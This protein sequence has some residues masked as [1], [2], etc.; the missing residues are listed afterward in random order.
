MSSYVSVRADRHRIEAVT[1]EGV[2]T[3]QAPYGHP[4]PAGRAVLEHRF[5]GVFGA[6][7]DEP[8]R[9]RVMSPQLLIEGDRTER[10][11]RGS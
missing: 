8:A 3:A 5:P 2:T 6:G 10:D 9:G 7:G 1:A 4:A 11:S